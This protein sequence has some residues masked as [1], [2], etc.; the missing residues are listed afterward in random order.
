MNPHVLV[1]AATGTV[2]REMVAALLSR[3][4]SFTAAVRS[5][6]KDKEILG[7]VPAVQFDYEF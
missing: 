2:G 5:V 1:T 4:I 3:N 7:D 6:D